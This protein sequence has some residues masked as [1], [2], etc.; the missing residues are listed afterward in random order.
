MSS[1][2][3][4]I[5]L[6]VTGSIAA[7]KSA[8]LVRLF[9]KKGYNVKVIMTDSATKLVAPLTFSTLSK[10]KVFVDFSDNGVWNNHVELGIWADVF[11]IAP[12]TANTLAKMNHGIAD[13]LLL[14]TFLSARCP[15]YVAPAMDL[16]MW[17]HVTTQDN[18]SN[19]EKKGINIIPVESGELASGLV[20]EGRM[21]EP[22][23]IFDYLESIFNSKNTLK[24]K[25][26]LITAGPTFESID[27]VRFIGNRST[28]KMGIALSAE[29]HR[30]G[31]EV[32]LII[33]PTK[34]KIPE[35][36]KVINVESA[37]K[38][39][40]KTM[41]IQAGQNAFILAAAVADYTPKTKSLTKIKKE[42]GDLVLKLERTKDIAAELGRIK[43]DDQILVGFAL[44]TDSEM[45]NAKQKLKKKNFDFIVLNSLKDKGAGFAHDTNKITI[46]SSKNNKIK[47]FELKSKSQVA[48]D[49]IDYLE[50]YLIK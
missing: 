25:K 50:S 30:R 9:V 27:P 7:Y 36:I 33:G 39:Y 46:I 21:A 32:T 18:I 13:N 8:F 48:I 4:N 6:G 3:K 23:F 41:E 1:P 24:G 12:A 34:E 43:K 11:L 49:I 17:K 37:A 5:L 15:V 47:N 42:K 22:E 45:T 28:G 44:E 19:L 40:E 35:G 14:T 16:D 20:G 2:V 26:I 38:M 29:A 10:N 31:A